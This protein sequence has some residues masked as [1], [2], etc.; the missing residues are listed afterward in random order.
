VLGEL[1]ID[2]ANGP[3]GRDFYLELSNDTGT[4]LEI[5]VRGHS[6]PAGWKVM[7]SSSESLKLEPW[8]SVRV[9]LVAELI[10]DTG[11]RDVLAPFT[12]EVTGSGRDTPSD[13]IFATCYARLVPKSPMRELIDSNEELRREHLPRLFS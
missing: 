12:V 6:V 13:R 1:V 9:N 4:R 5:G 2:L 3:V 11:L 10:N 8:G 7:F